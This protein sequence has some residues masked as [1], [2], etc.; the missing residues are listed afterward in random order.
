MASVY[1][2][3]IHQTLIFASTI[4]LQTF[5]PPDNVNYLPF[6]MVISIPGLRNNNDKQQAG[7]LMH[8]I[9]YQKFK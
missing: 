2:S 1:H 4:V 8:S 7:F 9:E 5:K 3:S 6:Q